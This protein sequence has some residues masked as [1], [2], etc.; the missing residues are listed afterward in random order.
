MRLLKLLESLTVAARLWSLVGIILLAM[1][2]LGIVD[3]TRKPESTGSA[4]KATRNVT[5]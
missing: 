4:T 3:T 2:S 5:A 1:T